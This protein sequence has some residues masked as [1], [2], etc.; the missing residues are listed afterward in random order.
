MLV[1]EAKEIVGGI[2]NPSKMP[3]KAYGLPA[4]ACKVGTALRQVKDSVCAS[5]YAFGRG[6][7]AMAPVLAA[8][9]RRLDSLANLPLWVEAM[10]TIIK[11]R[12]E[13]FRWHD[14]GDLQSWAHLLAIVSIAKQCETT[15]FWLPT[16]E[17]ALVIRHLKEVGKFPANLL[18]RL[19]GAMVDGKRPDFPHTS[20]V[21][22]A[23]DAQGHQ[24]PAPQQGGICG[25]CR[26]CWNRS[27]HNV[28]YHI[29]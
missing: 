25:D 29:H 3:G 13:W 14:S 10:V 6:R 7:Y 19:S 18:V 26:A 22:S 11:G 5:C 1:K 16:K 12:Q 8:Q 21:S 2:G 9:Y 23:G 28:T 24:C 15:N 4:A 27:V 20:S 17:K